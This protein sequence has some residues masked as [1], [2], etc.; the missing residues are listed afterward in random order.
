[1]TKNL[2]YEN[3]AFAFALVVLVALSSWFLR[4]NLESTILYASVRA[5][6]QLYLLGYV[7]LEPIFAAESPLL[8]F[9]YLVVVL[10]IAAR[11]GS[12]SP[13]YSYGFAL[14]VNAFAAISGSCVIVM[15]YMTFLVLRTDPWWKPDS[16]IPIAGMILGSS[17]S[18]F[19]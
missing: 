9:A 14:Y 13:S 18:S 3:L 17:I 12:V 8:V 11:E 2:S 4:L 15:A 16:F 1:M 7:L 19:R 10:F 6:V 5:A